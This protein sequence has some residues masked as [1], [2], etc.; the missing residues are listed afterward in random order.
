VTQF[1][2]A[3]EPSKPTPSSE[4]RLVLNGQ[5][6]EHSWVHQYSHTRS[7]SVSDTTAVTLLLQCRL[8]EIAEHFDQLTLPLPE[9]PNEHFG[10]VE[11]VCRDS[12]GTETLRLDFEFTIDRVEYWAKSWS[13]SDFAT[14]LKRAV[15]DRS[16]PGLC[17]YQPSE[18]LLDPGFGLR[19]GLHAPEET[20]Q[21]AL[22]RWLPII[23][24]VFEEVEA[25]LLG[26][27]RA[28]IGVR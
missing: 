3:W 11:I 23:R 21:Q 10:Q 1:G 22:E 9:A 6:I 27:H 18:E 25:S 8:T 19:I 4:G 26:R 2:I 7:A 13:M 16:V 20:V 24:N 5:L 15:E 28:A 17:Y 12:D 14:M